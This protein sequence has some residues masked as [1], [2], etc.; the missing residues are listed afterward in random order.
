MCKLEGG[1]VCTVLAYTTISQYSDINHTLI[2]LHPNYSLA[3]F[4]ATTLEY[5]PSLLY[6]P[7]KNVSVCTGFVNTFAAIAIHPFKL[8]VPILY[9]ISEGSISHINVFGLVFQLILS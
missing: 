5:T 1:L 9:Y 3:K 2:I 7:L 6:R 4:Y 8:R